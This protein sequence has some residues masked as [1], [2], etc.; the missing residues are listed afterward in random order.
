MIKRIITRDEIMLVAKDCATYRDIAKHFDISLEMLRLLRHKHDLRR[1]VFGKPFPENQS[2]ELL[3]K[4]KYHR[5]KRAEMKAKREEKYRNWLI[6]KES[7]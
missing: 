7:S 6:K 3:I 1:I 4:R 5:D 2:P